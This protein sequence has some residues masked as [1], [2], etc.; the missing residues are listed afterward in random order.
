MT[1]FH[2][3]PSV[4][5]MQLSQNICAMYVKSNVAC[6]YAG[7]EACTLCAAELAHLNSF[8]KPQYLLE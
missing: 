3:Y 2:Q 5:L 1:G 6:G 8:Q 7:N 4:G